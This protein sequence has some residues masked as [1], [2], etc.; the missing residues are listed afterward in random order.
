[1]VRLQIDISI[2]WIP[3]SCQCRSS[4]EMPNSLSQACLVAWEVRDELE[5]RAL[6]N[7]LMCFLDTYKDKALSTCE[8]AIGY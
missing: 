4:I 6:K 8:V 3:T 2:A 5:L 7:A 1:M